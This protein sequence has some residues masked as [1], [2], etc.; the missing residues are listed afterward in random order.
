MSIRP[1][2]S[3][4]AFSG[5][6]DNRNTQTSANSRAVESSIGSKE[7]SIERQSK[8]TVESNPTKPIDQKMDSNQTDTTAADKP[9]EVADD[10]KT[11]DSVAKAIRRSYKYD[12]PPVIFKDVDVSQS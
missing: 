7:P 10:S 4:V 9:E 11:E 8:Q 2:G 5:A 6:V 3:G 12:D 1:E